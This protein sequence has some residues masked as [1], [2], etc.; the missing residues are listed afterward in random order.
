[1]DP[2]FEYHTHRS[3]V[4]MDKIIEY[5]EHRRRVHWHK[6]VE[7]NAHGRCLHM[8]KIIT[9]TADACACTDQFAE[10]PIMSKLT[11][12]LTPTLIHSINNPD[13]RTQSYEHANARAL[14]LQSL[15]LLAGRRKWACVMATSNEHASCGIADIY[16]VKWAVLRRQ[17]TITHE[18]PRTQ[19]HTY[20]VIHAF[21]F[22]TAPLCRCR[23]PTAAAA[24]TPAHPSHCSVSRTSGSHQIR[25]APARDYTHCTHVLHANNRFQKK[26]RPHRPRSI[27]FAPSPATVRTTTA[28]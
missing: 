4:H 8:E 13:E 22:A 15:R 19:T 7:Y 20:S 12:Q 17:S 28:T 2:I 21:I 23:P 27:I 3:C 10:H 25:F 1:M 9:P 6:I 26:P 16:T 11:V 24:D 5:Q 14:R 18:A